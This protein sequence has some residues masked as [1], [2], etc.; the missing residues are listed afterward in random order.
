M[1]QSYVGEYLHLVKKGFAWGQIYVTRVM[2]GA[3]GPL[4]EKDAVEKAKKRAARDIPRRIVV[5]PDKLLMF[6]RGFEE[7]A[8]YEYL[9]WELN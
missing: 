4:S 1:A 8:V 2:R 6:E 9:S 5:D 3:K 7:G